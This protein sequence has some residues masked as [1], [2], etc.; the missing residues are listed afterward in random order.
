MST[1]APAAGALPTAGPTAPVPLLVV[2][3]LHVT[4]ERG[5]GIR[6]RLAG[7]PL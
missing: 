3:G 2:E 5:R 1:T 4:F 6:D 7:R